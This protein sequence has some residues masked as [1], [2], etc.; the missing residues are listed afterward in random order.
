MPPRVSSRGGWARSP[1]IVQ[2][3][4]LVLAEHQINVEE[5]HA[6]VESAPMSAERLF[7]PKA[8]RCASADVSSES[9]W[10]LHDPVGTDLLVDITVLGVDRK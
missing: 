7:V 8:C 3:T 4:A 9:L 6:G 1:G 2:K 10:R 5:L